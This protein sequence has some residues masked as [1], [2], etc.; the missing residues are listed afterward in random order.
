MTMETQDVRDGL[1]QAASHFY[2]LGW[3]WGT[4]GNLSARLP[5]GTLWITASGKSKGELT[6]E[7]FIRVDAAGAVVEPGG[8]GNKPSAETSIH[9]ALY[10][11]FP[12]ARACFHVHS[13][14]A[15]L[16][17]TLTQATELPLPPLEMLKGFG[18][19]AESPDVR[20]PLFDNHL[21][22]PRIAAEIRTRFGARAPQLAALLIRRHGITTWAPTVT[23]ARHQVELIEFLLRY[24]VATR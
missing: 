22:V 13:L 7:D 8:A 19:W 6:R 21:D 3:M 5:D 11:R 4:A 20:L 9:L 24:V 17:S 10:E 18:I 16:A 1:A 14:E 15:N 12:E 2:K 23:A